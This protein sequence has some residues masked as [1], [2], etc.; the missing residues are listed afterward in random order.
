[1]TGKWKAVMVCSTCS[2]YTVTAIATNIGKISKIQVNHG[3]IL[4]GLTIT[5]ETSSGPKTKSS[6]GQG[7]NVTTITLSGGLLFS[8]V[9]YH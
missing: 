7:G 9:Q 1:M 3:E 2:L 5:Y 4:D 6:G 8:I